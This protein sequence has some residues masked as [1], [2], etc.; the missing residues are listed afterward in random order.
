[1][2]DS[3]ALPPLGFAVLYRWRLKDGAENQFVEAWAA[4]TRFLREE[5]GALGSR[6]HRCDDGTYMAYAQWP[7]REA[8]S[9]MQGSPSG[10]PEASRIMKECI[11]E[12]L[13]DEPLTPLND[14]LIPA[15][16]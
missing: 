10:V 5:R 4:I 8:W 6:L 3:K 12:S 13:D 7:S 14:L 2:V 9:A 15:S 11:L 16:C 1:M